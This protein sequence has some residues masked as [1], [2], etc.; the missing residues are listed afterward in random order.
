MFA[1]DKTTL[2][3]ERGN[4]HGILTRRQHRYRTNDHSVEEALCYCSGNEMH[5]FRSD[6]SLDP[7]D[8][9]RKCWHCNAVRCT[10]AD[11]DIANATFD[12]HATRLTDE[13]DIVSEREAADHRVNSFIFR[14]EARARYGQNSFVFFPGAVVS[15]SLSYPSLSSVG[16]LSVSGGSRV[17]LFVPELFMSFPKIGRYLHRD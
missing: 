16:T 1:N 4:L 5:S 15:I 11:L 13:L 12:F 9:V 7:S 6:C 8:E 3:C 2:H 17:M 14:V 10:V